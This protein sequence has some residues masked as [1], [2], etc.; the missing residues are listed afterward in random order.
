MNTT[1]NMQ[2]PCPGFFDHAAQISAR[3]G[4]L[5]RTVLL[6]R[7]ANVDVAT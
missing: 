7:S 4:N 6:K 5:T 2:L 3:R 1:F